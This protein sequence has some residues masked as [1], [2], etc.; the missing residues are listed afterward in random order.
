MK[1]TPQHHTRRAALYGFAAAVFQY[2]DEAVVADLQ[3]EAVQDAVRQAGV[4]LGLD[5]E[6]DALLDALDGVDRDSLEPA[7]NRLF[8]LPSDEGTYPVVPYEAHYTTGDEVNESQRRIAT[9]VGLLEEF[10]LEISDEFDERHD[11]VTVELELLQVLAAQRAVAL[12]GGDDKTAVRLARAGATVLDEHLGDFV[13]AFAHRVRE[14]VD[15][16][17]SSDR[18]VPET[19][20]VYAAAAELAAALV[21]FDEAS[22]PDPVSPGTGVRADG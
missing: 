5:S 20:A 19:S 6:V 18:D 4:E 7:Y 8:G 10:G 12:D 9:V 3:D 14:T 21:E 2:P 13:P 1:N 17:G 16:D 15:G 11:H 22:H